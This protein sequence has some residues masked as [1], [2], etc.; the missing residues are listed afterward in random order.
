V[1]VADTVSMTSR[2]DIG[3]PQGSPASPS[4]FNIFIN[5]IFQYNF[6][7]RLQMYAND[8]ALLIRAAI[9]AEF[10]SKLQTDVDIM[11]EFFTCIGL[12][13]NVKKKKFVVFDQMGRLNDSFIQENRPML[14]GTA[15]ERVANQVY[16]G[17]HIDEGLTWSEHIDAVL[18]KLRPMVFAIKRSSYITVML[19][20]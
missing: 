10:M 17:I 8:V 7:G 11:N 2:I 18:K 16:L 20:Y 6:K 12:R 13:I 15:I 19:Q 4:M 1:C 3:L 9:L 5:S 14:N